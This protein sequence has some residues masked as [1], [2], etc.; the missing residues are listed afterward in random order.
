MAKLQIMILNENRYSTDDRDLINLAMD[1]LEIQ[2]GE[3]DKLRD[4]IT[5]LNEV[6]SKAGSTI[7]K[8]KS[9]AARLNGAKGGRPRKIVID[10]NKVY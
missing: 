3:I 1:R 2:D 8:A 6:Y 10:P 4:S 5:K 7:T 9:E